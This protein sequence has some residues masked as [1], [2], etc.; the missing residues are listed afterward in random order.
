[1]GKLRIGGAALPASFAA[2]PASFAA[3]PA[4]FAAPPA[5]LAAGG[6]TSGGP[7]SAT[8]TPRRAQSSKDHRLLA[9]HALRK[10]LLACGVPRKHGV[11]VSTQAPFWHDG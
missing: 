6:V 5:S 7:P 10:S 9:V 2:L 11:P 1:L 4:S 8:Q 3:P